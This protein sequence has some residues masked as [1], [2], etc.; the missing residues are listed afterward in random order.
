[1]PID[2]AAPALAELT[3]GAAEVLPHGGLEAKLKEKAGAPLRVKLGFDPTKPDL[4]IGHAVVLNALRRFQDQGHQVVV[5]IGDFTARIGDP[6]GKDQTRP[7]LS[8]DEVATNAKT[9]LDQLGLILDLSKAEI[10]YNGEWLDK[11]SMTDSV[12]LM[13]QTTVAQMLARDNFAKRYDRNDPISLHEFL[14]P[15]LQGYDSV[16]IRADVELGGTDQKFNVLMGRQL[17]ES[18]GQSPQVVMVFP[19]LEGTDGV[20]KMSKSLGNTIGLTDSA[21]EMVGKVMSIPD[22]LLENYYKL[23]SGLPLS[24]VTTAIEALKSG[25]LHPRDAKMTL[26]KTIAAR[27]HGPEAALHGEEA[28]NRQFQQHQLPADI[29]LHVLDETALSAGS[30]AILTTLGLTASNSEARRLMQQGGVKLHG[31]GD[32]PVTWTDPTKP[33]E[34]PDGGLVIQAGKRRFARIARG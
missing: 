28:F 24:E 10:H 27:Y 16:A 15:L 33:F 29:P 3:L 12:K 34:V 32:S 25:A 2:V 1:V 6:T 9:Y 8:A 23:A 4:H 18:Y 19:I 11:L 20:Q 14:Y 31:L 7:E 17:Q 5:I 26:A 13:A 22:S 21:E 30:G